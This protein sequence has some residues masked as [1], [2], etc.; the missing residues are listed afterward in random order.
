MDKEE[1]LLKMLC[2]CWN[3]FKELESQ[4]PS[5]TDDFCNGIHE[6]QDVIAL[7][8]ARKYRPDIFPIKNKKGDTYV[9]EN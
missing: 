2:E 1:E 7:R 5:E 3:K 8:F 4:H 6:C 9:K